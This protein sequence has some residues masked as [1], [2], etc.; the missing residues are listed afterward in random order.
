MSE[1]HIPN[2]VP[3]PGGENMDAKVKKAAQPPQTASGKVTNT[4]TGVSGAVILKA[5]PG[6]G[7]QANRKKSS[8]P[9]QT[10]M[11]GIDAG[12]EAGPD[13]IKIA[14]GGDPPDQR[15]DFFP[16]EE[17]A[18]RF[19]PGAT[20]DDSPERGRRDTVPARTADATDPSAGGSSASR[21]T[22]RPNG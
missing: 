19:N 20:E 8:G 1:P 16:P 11:T 10:G 3:E 13:N 6:P 15:L 18:N 12:D 17:G 5:D 7:T 4:G 9:P 22:R 14:E 2:A 21:V